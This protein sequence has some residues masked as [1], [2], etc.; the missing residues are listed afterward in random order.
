MTKRNE[1]SDPE[2]PWEFLPGDD[3]VDSYADERLA[4]E[5]SAMHVESDD[6][7]PLSRRRARRV[8]TEDAVVVHYLDDEEP[9]VPDRSVRRKPTDETPEVE[10]LLISQHYLAPDDSDQ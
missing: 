7:S 2:T 4:A 3:D 6:P 10:E 5:E 8:S 1:A 9:E